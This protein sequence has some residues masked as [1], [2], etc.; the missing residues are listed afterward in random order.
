MAPIILIMGPPG[1]GKSSQAKRLGEQEGFVHVSTGDLLRDSGDQEI[2]EVMKRGD[3]VD[4]SRMEQILLDK[5]M[6]LPQESTLVLDGFPREVVEAEWLAKELPELGRE[7]KRVILLKIDQAE[8][9]RRNLLRGRQDD[10]L[11]AQKERWVEWHEMTE[12]VLARYRA[13]NLVTEV[14][15]LGTP[16]EVAKRVAAVA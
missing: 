16:D 4:P 2:L 10:S 15:G 8:S 12:P 6:S 7:L 3:L 11:E 5:V 13:Q 9:E 14:D 1:A